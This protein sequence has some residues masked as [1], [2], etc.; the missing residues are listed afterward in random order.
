MAALH[1]WIEGRVQGVF[2]RDSTRRKADEL[3][4]V[5]WV[6]NLSDG[7]V[8]AFF[9]GELF[10]CKKALEYA[11]CGPAAAS[12]TGVKSNWEDEDPSLKGFSILY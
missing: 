6:R 4:L 10:L 2:F 11:G 12:V 5:G 1:V 3:G 9:Q 7:R 8:E